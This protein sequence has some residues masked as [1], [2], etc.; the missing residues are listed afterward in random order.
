M[1][2]QRLQEHWGFFAGFFAPAY[3]IAG[4][5]VGARAYRFY[6]KNHTDRYCMG[7]DESCGMFHTWIFF[8]ALIWIFIVT[9]PVTWPVAIPAV[10]VYWVTRNV[11]LWPVYQYIDYCK[12]AVKDVGSEK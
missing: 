10:T 7:P 9:A 6:V 5:W 2:I 4:G 8:H 1:L 12:K 3:L 11:L